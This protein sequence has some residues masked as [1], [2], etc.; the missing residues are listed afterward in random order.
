MVCPLYTW[1][2]NIVVEPGMPQL[3]LKKQRDTLI[4]TH[5]CELMDLG[6]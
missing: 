4:P 5:A 3:N 2:E 6:V 1:V